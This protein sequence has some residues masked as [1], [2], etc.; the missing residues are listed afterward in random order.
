[1]SATADSGGVFI[2]VVCDLALELIA[3]GVVVFGVWCLRTGRGPGA[4]P[5]GPLVPSIRTAAQLV[6]LLRQLAAVAGLLLAGL[7]GDEE[8]DVVAVR[9]GPDDLHL[10]LCAV[11]LARH[12]LRHEQM[13]KSRR[14]H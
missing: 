5:I 14:H 8:L 13:D 10:H 2:L 3:R 12:R 4:V 1:M 11:Q 6:H 7:L 9:L